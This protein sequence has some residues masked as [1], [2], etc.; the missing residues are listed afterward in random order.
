MYYDPNQSGTFTVTATVSVG[1]T[2]PLNGISGATVNHGYIFTPSSTES[3]LNF[4]VTASDRAGNIVTR[5]FDVERD[6]TAPMVTVNA[7][8]HIYS[9][10]IP[11]SWTVA[12][13]G[14]GPTGIYTVSVM[15]DTGPLQ[16]W[17]AGTSLTSGNFTGV[18]G[19]RYTFVV[20]TTDRV[21]NLGQGSAETIATQVTKYYYIGSTRV[22]MRQ[23][24]AVTYLHTDH[25]G[26]VSIA[27]NQSQAVLARTLN[28]PYGGVRWSSG[29][30]PT[31]WGYTG[32][33]DTGLGLVYMHARYYS[34]FTGRFVS[35]DTVVPEAGKPQTYNRYSY[36]SNNPIKYIDPTG[37]Q[38]CEW[39]DVECHQKQYLKDWTATCYE[40][41]DVDC[42]WRGYWNLA[43][44]GSLVGRTYAAKH[45]WN[46][47]NSGGDL[48]Y[49]GTS[50]DWVLDSK[51]AQSY[52]TQ[53][54]ERALAL[55]RTQAA[56]G[57][58]E[59]HVYPKIR[60]ESVDSSI[61]PDLYYAMNA[62]DLFAD[63]KYNVTR[64]PN[65]GFAV[66]VKYIYGF[67]DTYDWH[68]QWEAGGTESVIKEFRD[69][70]ADALREAG[71]ASTFNIG[72]YRIDSIIYQYT[73]D[74][75]WLALNVAPSP[76]SVS[77]KEIR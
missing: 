11:V 76:I 61:D 48:V 53:L 1:G 41:G 58:L 59:G 30:M 56:Q 12:E 3:G 17:L 26:T 43:F 9:S 67:A 60:V 36:A 14:S 50:A 63:A 15:T 2:Y 34:S 75:N 44:F 77:S 37:H 70:W 25:L 66:D 13:L 8:S 72:G 7:P 6:A 5:T 33:K 49:A 35:A 29:T 68:I 64:Q 23:G 62:F 65:G 73:F 27:T 71:K 10:T 28:L 52:L 38:G 39:S 57:Q 22:A 74:A 21:N 40:A 19:H 51:T 42:V 46:F 45:L 24:D 16:P 55:V 18:L 47:L 54:Q 32:Q 69:E 31:D 20:T 4:P